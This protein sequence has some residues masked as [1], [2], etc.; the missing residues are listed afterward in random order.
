M[1]GASRESVTRAFA[2]LQKA[3][4]LTL[5]HRSIYVEDTLKP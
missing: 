3:G 2:R 4:A 5:R 1:I